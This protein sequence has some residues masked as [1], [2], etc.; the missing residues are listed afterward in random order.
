MNSNSRSIED[1][2]IIRLFFIWRYK[3]N[4]RKKNEDTLETEMI[5]FKKNKQVNYN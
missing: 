3:T 4:K 1:M 5:E 2:V